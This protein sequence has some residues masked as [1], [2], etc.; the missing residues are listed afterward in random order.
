M[1]VQKTNMSSACR[2]DGKSTF[3]VQR[4]T[5]QPTQPS[6]SSNQQPTHVSLGMS[7]CPYF[8]K[9]RNAN[10]G[11]H[12]VSCVMDAKEG[13]NPDV[14]KNIIPSVG[15]PT[16]YPYN[17]TLGENGEALQCEA[18]LDTHFGS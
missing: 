5:Q 3:T 14:C 2:N 8:N 13:E 16:G 10:D 9:Q 18:G 4:S 6:D 1:Y 7:W 17:C 11:T 12:V 15:E